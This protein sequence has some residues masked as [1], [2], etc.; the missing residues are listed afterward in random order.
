MHINN[1]KY[2]HP[3][4]SSLPLIPLTAPHEFLVLTYHLSYLEMFIRKNQKMHCAM[5]TVC[6]A[7]WYRVYTH[8]KYIK[9]Y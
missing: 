4:K 6:G 1:K 8:N 5:P 7:E 2:L 9:N 3:Y